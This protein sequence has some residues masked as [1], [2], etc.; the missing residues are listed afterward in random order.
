MANSFQIRTTALLRQFATAI[1]PDMIEVSTKLGPQTLCRATFAIVEYPTESEQREVFLQSLA[2]R[3]NPEYPTILKD[4]VNL[5]IE[6]Q[7][8][9]VEQL[10]AH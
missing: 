5:C 10:L 4:K 2:L 6:G 1:G 3:A 9:A 8:Q 7:A